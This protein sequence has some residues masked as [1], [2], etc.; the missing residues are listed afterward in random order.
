[1]LATSPIRLVLS[2]LLWLG[3]HPGFEA[4]EGILATKRT[5]PPFWCSKVRR[6][7]RI[8]GNRRKC[9]SHHHRFGCAA[10]HC[11]IQVMNLPKF[12]D[13]LGC[14]CR[15]NCVKLDMCNSVYTS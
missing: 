2:R 5:R 11:C 7:R 10:F 3:D 12:L 9:P 4:A 6:C 15:I 1:M 8:T 13:I 14:S